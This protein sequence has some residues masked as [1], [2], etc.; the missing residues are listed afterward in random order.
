M[1]EISDEKLEIILSMTAFDNAFIRTFFDRNT[2]E[3]LLRLILKT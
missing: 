3:F 1:L 2:V